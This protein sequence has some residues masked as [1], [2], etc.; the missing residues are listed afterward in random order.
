MCDTFSFKEVFSFER[1]PIGPCHKTKLKASRCDVM[2]LR[3]I[4]TGGR[5]W[6]TLR[7]G[8]YRDC[9]H[10]VVVVNL[11]NKHCDC[12]KCSQQKSV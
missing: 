5:K 10:I 1:P 8:I 2:I 3:S 7:H 6:Q 9:I 4:R 12:S 11:K